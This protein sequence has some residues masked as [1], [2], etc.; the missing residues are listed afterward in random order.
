MRPCTKKMEI[1]LLGL[2]SADAHIQM[3]LFKNIY[4]SN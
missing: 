3:D 2:V 4:N 1:I